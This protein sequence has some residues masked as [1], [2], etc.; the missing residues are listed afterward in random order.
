MFKRLFL[1]L[2]LLPLLAGAQ[3]L[4]VQHYAFSIILSD[5]TDR[6]EGEAGVSVRLPAGDTAFALDL[7]GPR[8]NGKGMGVTKIT[9]AALGVWR[10]EK[11]RIIIGL[12]S[13]AEAGKD[14]SFQ[15]AYG[16]VPD[17]G[18]IISKNKWGDRTFFADNWPNR[19]HHWIPC[20][21]RPDD[22]ATFGFTVYAPAG[23]D[24]IS[25]GSP[26]P[27]ASLDPVL[28]PGQKPRQPTAAWQE[29]VPS[30]TKVMVIG[31]AKFAIREY[32]NYAGQVPVSA[33]VFPQDS[34]HGF[35]D[36]AV[37][38][39]ILDFFSKYIAPFP[40][41]KLANVQSKTIFGGMENASC[42]FYAE[43]SVAGNR[44]WEDVLAHEIAHQ[45]F[46]DMASE[47]SFAHLWLSEGFATYFTNIYWQQ[48]YG[49]EAFR[50][51]LEDDRKQVI[52]FA[53]TSDHAVV[54][55]TKDL[56]SLLNA[57]SYQKGGW[58]L[59]M[60]RQQVGDSVFQKIIRAYYATY[61]G[62]NADTHDF[63]RIADSVYGS[64]ARRDELFSMDVFFKEWLH[65]PGVPELEFRPV[66]GGSG[67]FLV[68][69]LGTIY[70]FPIEIGVV[71]ES[72]NMEL[73]SFW[74]SER[75]TTLDLGVVRPGISLKLDPNCK[76][77]FT[78]RSGGGNFFQKKSPR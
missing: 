61:K 21:D 32:R 55:S 24:V 70:H 58:V 45:W 11:D 53:K 52:A 51:R 77:L 66:P 71:S 29:S 47:K 27:L 44:K 23:Y 63:E 10:Q 19:A 69:Q 50:K 40:Y 41:E 49:E 31:V 33:W 3:G 12:R 26:T 20:N 59:H 37:A 75:E 43:E 60:L 35:Y 38:P 16:G 14:Y 6:I 67:A 22:K 36:Y 48:K 39:E 72:G 1:L 68:K 17:D 5:T 65:R 28:P 46:G 64:T 34:A 9:G 57:N 73:R 56:M 74:I 13:G 30:S 4:D 78:S 15:I 18:L 7:Y 2:F 54:D 62:G 42:I 25:N 8:P 76:L